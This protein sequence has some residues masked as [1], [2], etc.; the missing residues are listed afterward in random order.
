MEILFLVPARAGSKRLMSKNLMPIAGIPLVARAVRLGRRALTALGSGGRLVCSTEDERIAQTA[1]EWGAEIPFRRPAEL[2]RDETPS[3]AVVLHALAE[4]GEQWD[5]VV[6]L[7]PTSPLA[8]VK[9]VLGAVELFQRTG[10]PVVSVCETD[11]PLAWAQWMNEAGRLTPVLALPRVD[12]RQQAEVAYRP[13]GAVYIARPDQIRRFEGFSGHSTRGYPMA[14]EHSVDID[15]VADLRLADAIL[16]TREVA[17]VAIGPREVGP[18][19]PCLVVAEAGVNHNGSLELAHR[20]VDAAADAGA[21]AV[22]FQTYLTER[23][24]AADAPKAPYQL[25]RT[26]GG[27]QFEMLKRL[28]L[29]YAWH[30][31]LKRHADE[32]GILFL[33]TPDDIASARFLCE[34][35]VPAIKV[36]SA[37][38]TNV[39]F[40]RE[41]AELEKPLLL[42]TGMATMADVAHAIDAVQETRRVPMVLLHCVSSYPAP[43]EELNLRCIGSMRSAF[44][45]PVG[46]SDHTTSDLGAIMGIAYEIAVLEKHLTLDRTLSGPDHRMSYDPGG[47]KD[48]VR[49]VRQADRMIGTGVKAITESERATVAVVRR[50]LTYAETLEQGHVLRGSDLLALRATGGGLAPAVATRL[51]GRALKRRVTSGSTVS[52]A[53]LL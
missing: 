16:A 7:Q 29:P 50:T 32:R 28:E 2:A 5:A 40:L 35:G 52:E 51:I 12:R 37:E 9:D 19:H 44:G 3:T 26:G 46:L 17:T 14:R 33:S 21:D 22:K 49:L 15:S 36:G 53:D 38:L 47:F 10:D 20:L 34:V 31:E 4:M 25:E 18:G 13:N 43:E 27:S 45:V 48:L 39:P 11:H 1:R 30:G 42:S 6:L 23:V 41:L 24:C 8:D